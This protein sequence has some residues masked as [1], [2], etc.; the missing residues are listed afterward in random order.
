MRKAFL[1]LMILLLAS[2]APTG[3]VPADS[4]LVRSDPE[5]GAVLDKSPA[6]VTLEFSEAPDPAFST[7][8]IIDATTQQPLPITVTVDASQAETVRLMFPPLKTGVYSAQWKVRSTVDGHIITSSI[9]FSVGQPQTPLSLLPAPGAPDPATALPAWVEVYI[10]WLAYASLALGL[11]SFSF[12]VLVWRPALR[13]A[14]SPGSAADVAGD[15]FVKTS[16]VGLVALTVFSAAS[17]VYQAAQLGVGLSNNLVPLLLSQT[18]LLLLGRILLAIFLIV[19]ALRL[20]SPSTGSPGKWWGALALGVAV[21]STFSLQSHLAATGSILNIFNETLHL[22]S[23]V[24]WMGG[25]VPLFL[26]I[27]ATRAGKNQPV[28]L[29][30]LIPMFSRRLSPA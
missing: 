23:M 30:I 24:A 27:R 18:S 2:F 1:L 20:P 4:N 28:P 11:G 7:Y 25:L 9:T 26:V 5:N 17:L 13:K 6:Q 14:G 15:L 3:R 8:Q 22:G 16:L 12:A 19:W 10:R 29:S 21:L